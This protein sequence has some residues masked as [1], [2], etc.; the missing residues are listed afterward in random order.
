LQDVFLKNAKYLDK[1]GTVNPLCAI[2][3][4]RQSM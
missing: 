3:E 2:E 1:L 4:Y